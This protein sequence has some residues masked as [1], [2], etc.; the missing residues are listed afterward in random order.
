MEL[1][2]WY[3]VLSISILVMIVA[4]LPVKLPEGARILADTVQMLAF[5]AFAA[6]VSI[7]LFLSFT[8]GL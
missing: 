6:S 5:G 2:Y 4:G 3:W 1:Y 8:H 7:L